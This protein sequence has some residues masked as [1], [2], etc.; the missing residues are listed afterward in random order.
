MPSFLAAQPLRS[1]HQQALLKQGLRLQ[2]A[3]NDEFVDRRLLLGSGRSGTTWVLDCLSR[4]NG[5]RPIFEPLHEKE[6]SIGARYAYSTLESGD[7]HPELLQ[8]F[9]DLTSGHIHSRWIDYRVP[10]DRLFPN[11]RNLTSLQGLRKW[12][13]HW[14]HYRRNVSNLRA[15]TSHGETLIKC[16]RANLM[17]N[18]LTADLGSRVVLVVRHPCAVVESQFRIGKVW[19]PMQVTQHYRSNDRLHVL[20]DGRYLELL[21]REL[22]TIQALTLNWVIENQWPLSCAERRGFAVVCYEHLLLH[23]ASTW[24]AVCEWL[25]LTSVPVD[26]DLRRPSQ[27][28]SVSSAAA[29]EGFEHQST[30]RKTL[31]A[32][33]LAEIQLVLDEV[34]FDL[35]HVTRALPLY[36]PFGLGSVNS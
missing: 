22:T 14:L 18:W 8:Y 15:L 24:P 16:I 30:W 6:S 25:N 32:E 27:T 5:L 28:T 23:S 4:A 3:M 21:K 33:Q 29:A 19:D 17:A 20:T 31:S 36:V 35:Y 1:H 26:E 7:H 2:R 34:E 10:S 9:L 12:R 13:R 11:A